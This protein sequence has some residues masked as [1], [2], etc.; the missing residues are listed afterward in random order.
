MERENN[1]SNKITLIGA[2]ALQQCDMEK[3]MI[4][5]PQQ[6]RNIIVVAGDA[7]LRC[8]TIEKAFGDIQFDIL[9]LGVW[10]LHS[11]LA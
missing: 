11:E 3:R 9:E 10:Q 1:S 7:L 5:N 6:L 2:A 8:S 4:Y